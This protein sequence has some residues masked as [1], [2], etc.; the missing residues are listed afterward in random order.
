[1]HLRELK[2]VVAGKLIPPVC[3]CRLLLCTPLHQWQNSYACI[4]LGD[5]NFQNVQEI[6]LLN[7]HLEKHCSVK[8]YR[9]EKSAWRENYLSFSKKVSK[10]KKVSEKHKQR[11]K[12]MIVKEVMLQYMQKDLTYFFLFEVWKESGI[13]NIHIMSVGFRFN[14]FYIQIISQRQSC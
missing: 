4:L 2:T 10:K 9:R 14:V 11:R 3:I 6:S 8:G 5:K 12:T 7:M 1:M 13:K